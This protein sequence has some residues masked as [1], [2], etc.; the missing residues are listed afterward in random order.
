M[1]EHIS[2][3]QIRDF[4]KLFTVGRDGRI[5]AAPSECVE[6]GRKLTVINGRMV[7]YLFERIGSQFRKRNTPLQ[8]QNFNTIG[9]GLGSLDDS[10][11]CELVRLLKAQIHFFQRAD[12]K[13]RS[14][15]VPLSRANSEVTNFLGADGAEWFLQPER[16]SDAHWL[17][18]L[19]QMARSGHKTSEIV[20]NSMPLPIILPGRLQK[21]QGP[22]GLTLN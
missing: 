17:L 22:S 5:D 20:V 7:D 2:N 12:K 3:I 6:L 19:Q 13:L 1:D 15:L 10:A 11:S 21:P 4:Q 18:G 8:I 9:C 16:G 14:A